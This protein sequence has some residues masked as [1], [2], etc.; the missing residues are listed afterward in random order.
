MHAGA[1]PIQIRARAIL[2]LVVGDS[3]VFWLVAAYFF[4]Q[5]SDDVVLLSDFSL[6]LNFLASDLALQLLDGRVQC[7]DFKFEFASVPVHIH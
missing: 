1:E 2:A 4:F 3:R 6:I 7:L 5:I